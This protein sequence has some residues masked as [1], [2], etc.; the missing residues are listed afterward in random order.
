MTVG[1][2]SR[3]IRCRFRLDLILRHDGD[4]ATGFALFV[5][6]AIHNFHALKIFLDDFFS[7][8]FDV[9][10]HLAAGPLANAVHHVFFHQN[11]NLL[12]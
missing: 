7:G 2:D 3:L 9:L 6:L 8:E 11:P 4:G 10:F 1:V 12:G 5:Y